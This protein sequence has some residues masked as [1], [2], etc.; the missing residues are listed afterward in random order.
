MILAAVQ[1]ALCR[2]WFN[3]SVKRE[4][5]RHLALLS[6]GWGI[7]RLRSYVCQKHNPARIEYLKGNASVK[8]NA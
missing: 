4:E 5:D 7:S 2:F 8:A 6:N 1:C 3:F